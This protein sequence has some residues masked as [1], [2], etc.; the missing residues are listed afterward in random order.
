[1]NDTRPYRETSPGDLI[2]ADLFNDVQVQ[3]R[4]EI[5]RKV[6]E[7]LA[8]V[9]EVD[10]ARDASKLE[11][12]TAQEWADD[13]VAR[14]VRALPARTGYRC[15][16]RRLSQDEPAVVRHGLG[17]YPLVEVCQLAR[18][19][20]VASADEVQT[21]QDVHWFLYHRSEMKIRKPKKGGFSKW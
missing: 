5:I 21:V 15:V 13:I 17:A 12:K 3:T 14:A 1:M 8:G 2:T 7:A 9:K 11:G 6:A 4:E 16:F 18:F 20:V 10:R 19:Q